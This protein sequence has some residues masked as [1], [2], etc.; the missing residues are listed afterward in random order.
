MWLSGD[1]HDAEDA[2]LLLCFVTLLTSGGGWTDFRHTCT[3]G[4]MNLQGVIEVSAVN[5]TQVTGGTRAAVIMH[6]GYVT[7]Q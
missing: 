4:V 2:N 1:W 7:L 6:T 5:L 3:H